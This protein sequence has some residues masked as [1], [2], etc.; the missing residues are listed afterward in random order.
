[1]TATRRRTGNHVTPVTSDAVT[2]D[3][4][5]CDVPSPVGAVTAPSDDALAALAKALGHPVRIKI[6]RLLGVRNACVTGDVVAELPLAQ[7]TVSEHLRIL[8]EAGL[9]EGEIE[10]PR[11]RY[12]INPNGL[13]VLKAGVTAL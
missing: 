10:G 3:A 8:R 11:T 9:I 13:A 6:L 2:S 12:C 1:M 5:C 7:S 4:E